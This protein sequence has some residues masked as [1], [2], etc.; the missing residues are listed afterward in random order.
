SPMRAVSTTP[1]PRRTTTSFSSTCRWSSEAA[2]DRR[3]SHA[4]YT[5]FHI[6]KHA[7]T[8]LLIHTE[9]S[10]TLP[11][12]IAIPDHEEDV[13]TALGVVGPGRWIEHWEPENEQ[14]WEAKG[15][16]IARRN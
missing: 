1:W 3:F 10:M 6:T 5:P 15:K 12:A 16:A 13:S 14:F 9:E 2:L 7:F 8:R 11:A 4:V